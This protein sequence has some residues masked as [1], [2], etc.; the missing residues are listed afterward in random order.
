MKPCGTSF[1]LEAGT[2]YQSEGRMPG[3]FLCRRCAGGGALA[4]LEG[5]SRSHLRSPDLLDIVLVRRAKKS[6]AKWHC[7]CFALQ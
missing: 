1:V 3:S 7:Q 4:F 2:K 6:S 5:R